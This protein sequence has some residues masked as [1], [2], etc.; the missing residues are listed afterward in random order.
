MYAGLYT[1][2]F[3]VGKPQC[4]SVWLCSSHHISFTGTS[5]QVTIK[6]K[7]EFRINILTF[8]VLSFASWINFWLTNPYLLWQISKI[9]AGNIRLFSKTFRK[10]LRFFFHLNSL[11]ALMS[12]YLAFLCVCAFAFESPRKPIWINQNHTMY[13]SP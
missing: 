1:S 6:G 8:K 12:S 9:F 3:P 10:P 13:Y 5:P 7:T 2:R 11:K 4:Y